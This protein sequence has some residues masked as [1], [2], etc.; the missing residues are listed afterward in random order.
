MGR[1][2]VWLERGNG[3]GGRS[4]AAGSANVCVDGWPNCVPSGESFGGQVGG[5]VVRLMAEPRGG[6]TKKQEI[7]LATLICGVQPRAWPSHGFGIP[8]GDNTRSH[9]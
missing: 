8:A 7:A 4:C 3:R 9:T 6:Q 1:A 2:G 5:R